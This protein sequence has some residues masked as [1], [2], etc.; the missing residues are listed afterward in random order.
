MLVSMAG[1]KTQ[2]IDVRDLTGEL[3]RTVARRQTKRILKTV[4][5]GALVASGVAFSVVPF[6]PGFPLIL[7]GLAVL[8]TEFH[9]ARRMQARVRSGLRRA[10]SRSRR[11][12]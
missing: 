12:R 6:V 8:A 7:V 2:N 3:P 9:W 5:G 10:R 1:E 11:R 4:A